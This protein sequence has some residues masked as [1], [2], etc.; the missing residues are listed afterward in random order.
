MLELY[1]ALIST[2]LLNILVALYDTVAF[3]DLGIAIAVLTLLVRLA[4]YPL[5][6]RGLEQQAKMQQLQPHIAALK[7]KHKGNHEAHSRALMALYK[8]HNFNPFSGIATM[9]VQIPILIALYHLF[10]GVFSD[11]ALS[12]VYSFIPNPGSLDPVSLGIIDLQQPVFWLVVVTAVL[13]FVQARMAVS[14]AT[15]TDKAQRIS[16]QVVTFVAPVITLVIFAQL[17]AAVSVYWLVSS[18]LSVGQQYLAMKRIAARQEK[19]NEP[20]AA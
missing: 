11:A 1:H 14:S 13:Q 20:A 18:L 19:K 3:Q 9:L 4:F 2:P 15:F 7:D 17:P 10:L 16:S 8:E 6:Q 12:R 5:F